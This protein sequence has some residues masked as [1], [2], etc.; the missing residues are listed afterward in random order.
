MLREYSKYP[1]WLIDVE[2]GKIW[3]K[4]LK[5]NI[6]AKHKDG[7]LLCSTGMLHRIIWMVAN[8]SVI[9]DGYE[10]HHIDG[11]R[12]NNS[13]NNLEL[14]ESYEHKSEHKKGIP[15]TEEHKRK[16]SESHK[17]ISNPKDGNNKLSYFQRYNIK[18]AQYTLNDELVRTYDSFR[19]IERMGF[20]RRHIKKICE[21]K[22]RY[23]TH[24]GFKWRYY[25]ETELQN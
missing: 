18:I 22:D 3:S 23:K 4:K 6:G 12:T 24:K 19:E 17:G 10:I 7:Y 5:K 2:E 21:N 20:D 15:I 1:Q 25:N 13:I 11:N 16:I 8:D 14:V 9:P